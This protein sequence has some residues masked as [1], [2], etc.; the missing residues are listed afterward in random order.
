MWDTATCKKNQKS[1][2]AIH[3]SVFA[4]KMIHI[5]LFGQVFCCPIRF[6]YLLF[7]QSHQ[8]KFRIWRTSSRKQIDVENGVMR[9]HEDRNEEHNNQPQSST[10]KGSIIHHSCLSQSIAVKYHLISMPIIVA[11]VRHFCFTSSFV[12]ITHHS[13]CHQPSS[14]LFSFVTVTRQS[15][16]PPE[17][18]C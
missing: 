9:L 7:Y 15:H 14:T 6:I 4:N 1:K 17:N 5:S 2:K 13:H 3:I 11:F 12:V 16:T 10:S 8:I 18:D